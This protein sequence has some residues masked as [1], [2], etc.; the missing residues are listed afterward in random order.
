M[1][2]LL[3]SIS[4]AALMCVECS[5]AK[6]ATGIP[7]CIQKM[8]N[9]IKAQPRWNPPATVYEYMYNGRK[10]FLFSADCCDQFST[11]YAADCQLIC[12]PYGGI[13]GKGDGKCTD[14][15]SAAKEVKLV[16]KDER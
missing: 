8:I 1:K 4:L 12:A 13:T 15:D 16:W 7:L 2:V 10:V 3:W 9:D 11:L 6:E 14:F 5:S